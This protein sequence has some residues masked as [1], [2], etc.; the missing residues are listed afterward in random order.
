VNLAGPQVEGDAGQRLNAGERLRD[1]DGVEQPHRRDRRP[2]RGI[3]L[4]L[5]YL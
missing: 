1:R 5:V 4:H 3:R 2:F